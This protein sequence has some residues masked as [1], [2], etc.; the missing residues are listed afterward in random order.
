M[1]ARRCRKRAQVS[2]AAV[3]VDGREA[4]D[5]F[6]AEDGSST[7]TRDL[8]ALRAL[9]GTSFDVFEIFAVS[10]ARFDA[11]AILP[12]RPHPSSQTSFPRRHANFRQLHSPSRQCMRGP[13]SVYVSPRLQ[14]RN[15]STTSSRNSL[16][17]RG[18]GAT[19]FTSSMTLVPAAIS[20]AIHLLL[21]SRISPIA[22]R[23]LQDK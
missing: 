14:F 7:S 10:D 16:S 6:V 2:H 11:G 13:G 12:R 19:A 9:A 8:Q 18:G 1:L 17:F 4:V 20:F 3:F 21:F 23:V 5:A 15:R 22:A